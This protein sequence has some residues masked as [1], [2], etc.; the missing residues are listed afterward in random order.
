MVQQQE[1][2]CT[3][4]L[5]A[6][7]NAAGVLD[8]VPP[9]AS[10]GL[11]ELA[12]TLDSVA[13]GI[14]AVD[15][16]GRCTFVNR[17]ACR[18][19][20]YSREECLGRRLCMLHMGN[21][22]EW[23]CPTES[24]GIQK[25]L[26]CRSNADLD[27][28]VFRRR[29]GTSIPVHCS[30]QP[31][32][33]QGR[34][35][36]AVISITDITPQKCAE[37]ALR[38]SD[39]WLGFAQHVGNVGM[40]DLDLKTREARASEGQ[41]RVYGLNPA[42]KWPSHEEWRQLIHPEDR[43]RMD[44][45]FELAISGNELPGIDFRV[46]WPNGSIHWLF[47]Q[48]TVVFDAA[49]DA[50]RLMGANIDVTS[51]V[52]A[53]TTLNQFFYSSPSPLSILQFGGRIQQAN[54]AW[55]PIL[56]F[57]PAEMA[58]RMVF[59][60]VHPD[61]RAIAAAEFEKLL[62]S[63]QRTGVECRVQC[64]DGSYRWLL[65]NGGVHKE[66]QLIYVTANDITN[67]KKAEEAVQLSEARFRSAFENTL[68][69]MAITGL[70]GG[71]LRVNQSFCRLTGFSESDLLQSNV[72]AI[73]HPDDLPVCL[74][75]MHGLLSGSIPR[76]ITTKRFLRRDGTP[77]WVRTHVALERDPAGNPLHY[78]ALVEDLTDQKRAEKN[79]RTSEEWLKFTLNA[80]GIGLRL[81]VS[82]KT[83]VSDQQFRLYGLE[84][85]EKWIS[86]ERWLQCI[87]PED[88][89]RVVLEEGQG[90]ERGE[91]YDLVFRVVW[92]DGNIHWLLS[93]ETA[94][95]DG[96]GSQSIEVTMDITERKSAELAL[97]QFFRLSRSPMSILGFDGSVKRVNEA[98][99][100]TSGF[101]PEHLSGRPESE[102]FHPDDRA[103]LSVQMR[104]LIAHGGDTE[105]E[106]RGLRTDGSI[107][108]LLFSATALLD[109]NL[110]FTVST[111]ITER[112]KAEEDL[113]FRNALLSTQQE[114]SLDGILVVNDEARV[115]SYNRR[116]SEMWGVPP[117][118]LDA[119]TDEPLLNFVTAQLE[120][121]ESFRLRV[122]YL[123]EHR[124]ET[125][126]DEILLKGGRIFD[127][128]SAPM[129]GPEGRYYGRVW[130]FRDVTERQRAE[131]AVRESEKRFKLIAETIDDVFWINAADHLELSYV[132]P[133][134]ERIW[135]RPRD[136][137]CKDPQS[138]LSTIHRDD[139]P[140]I[141]AALAGLNSG[142]PFE[143]EFRIVRP[144]GTVASILDR[145]FPVHD[146]N[147][148]LECYI[149]T[150][151][152]ITERKRM[153][154]NLERYAEK[155]ARSNT[156]LE[157]F[158]YVASHDLQEP[159]RMVASFTQLLSQRYSGKLD[160][161]ADRYIHYAVDGAKRMQ[162]L[163]A[164]LL[165]YSRVNSKEL[166]IRQTGGETVVVA[167][168]Q[169]LRAAVE[170]TGATVDWDP[171][172]ELC[173]DQ[174]QYV[175]LFQNL[176][177]N[178][179]KFRRKEESPR[180]HISAVKSGAEWLISVRDNGI[181]IEPRHAER[182]FQIFQRLHARGE[183]PGTGIGLAVCKKVVERHGG[184][185]WV[186]SEPAKG[187]TFYFTIPKEGKG[188]TDGRANQPG[189]DYAD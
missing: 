71:F 108:W 13:T 104:N 149:G 143:L 61:D 118:L 90:S 79:A 50:A 58:G 36:G 158:A 72:P 63:G 161:T 157:Q 86:R 135:G 187:S 18:T 179:I 59:D 41:F 152:D 123:Y 24:C 132:S 69:G 162:Q 177:A 93:R 80:A 178:A 53:E 91:P 56:G 7:G 124:Q 84:P 121:P 126:T 75:L 81:R 137:V 66:T 188:V 102:F 87:H 40:F 8:P 155:L 5:C 105:F 175:Q 142:L 64:K 85:A 2:S 109:E 131:A 20:G 82:G 32:L 34:L 12:A 17:A 26:A 173:V 46:V 145:A 154:E 39:E 151:Q 139:L 110:I 76:G 48:V 182:V 29:D 70:D 6:A 33:L 11:E 170:E 19:F 49:G 156:E 3:M 167:A 147:G 112:K 9:P 153:M 186:E 176:L 89:E 171:L 165:A 146:A 51:R 35:T 181:G 38:A 37:E 111:D 107:V 100:R 184:K 96:R 88:R 77:V 65:L 125:S 4:P 114:V 54:A 95:P 57:T 30:I 117:G 101:S 164:D 148:K 73:T 21:T 31:V 97:E 25:A 44:R 16:E 22:G 127:R 43:E 138:F 10:W 62:G 144:D 45:Q 106:C 60:L 174:G 103:A 130:Y 134:Y 42:G 119:G 113:H 159:L 99:L 160:E 27:D 94:V 150:A 129:F 180:I 55:E 183:F 136:Q 166:D 92:P 14:W 133:A 115:L 78:I 141:S 140:G 185:I 122:Q 98:L 67:R 1:A 169:N 23:H 120:D 189:R 28:Q 74:E 15:L 83:K 47:G 163:I 172:P 116:F 68:F 128:Y 52:R 168:V